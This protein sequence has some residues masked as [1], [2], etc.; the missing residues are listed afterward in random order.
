MTFKV[1]KKLA[2]RVLCIKLLNGLLRRLIRPFSALLPKNV[3]GR[4]PV[5][6]IVCLQLPNSG[7]VYLKADGNDHAASRLYWAGTGALKN[8]TLG[9]FIKLLQ[10]AGT[11]FDIGAN[12]GVYALVAGVHDPDRRVYAFEPV[13][14]IFDYL[15]DNVEVNKLQNVEIHPLAITDYDGD[16]TLYVPAD[17]IPTSASILEGFRDGC[18]AISV[19]AS[20]IDSFVAMNSISKVDLIKMDTEATEHLVLQGAKNTIKRD[21]PIIIC[22]VLKG[23]TEE[24]LHCVLDTLRYRY[25]WISNGDL[26]ETKRIEGGASCETLDYLFVAPKQV[27][28]VFKKVSQ[29]HNLCR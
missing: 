12:T 25:F 5:V 6:G 20:T 22:E 19:R 16:I 7:K 10:E 1:V 29:L 2:K 15:K 28:E 24:S 17:I 13:P 11:V 18:E 9:L 4:I 23:R 3:T 21:E 14:R 8:S 27:K 26:I